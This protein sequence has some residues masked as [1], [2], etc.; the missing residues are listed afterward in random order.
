[1]VAISMA[2][3]IFHVR[4]VEIGIIAVVLCRK[5][6]FWHN[7]ALILPLLRQ[8]SDILSELASNLNF[9]ST[10]KAPATA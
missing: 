9:F 4:E 6:R 10:E 2:G 1:M 7:S 5:N 3:L 8:K